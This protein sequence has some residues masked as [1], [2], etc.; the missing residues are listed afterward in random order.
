MNRRHFLSAS[1]LAA[2]GTLFTG[3][4]FA[5][6]IG[7][8]GR[9]GFLAKPHHAAK[10]K[11][12]IYLYMSGGPSQFESFD[13]KPMLEKMD[14]KPMPASV[15]A[16]QQLAQI[17]G[18]KLNCFGPRFKFAKHGQSGVEISDKFP[19]L[20]KVADE[21]AVV[22]SLFT[23]QINHDPANTLL[24]TGSIL[25]DRPSM[26]SWIDYALGADC[27]DL[28]GFVVMESVKGGQGQP[29]AGR[30]WASGALPGVHQ[31]VKLNSRGPLVHFSGNP[32]GV[33]KEQQLAVAA[34]SGVLNRHAAAE[35]ADIEATT[36]SQQLEMALRMQ[37]SIPKLVD[38]SK[39]PQSTLDLY[40]CKP[41]DGSFASNC[42]M[43]RR[44]VEKGCRFIQLYHRDWDHHG[45]I[46]GQFPVLAGVVD[47]GIYALITDLKQRG[48][49]DDTL[50]V[51]SGEFGRTPMSQG[52]NGRDHHM[53]CFSAFMA[54]GGIKGGTTHG[55]SDEFG[56]APAEH[57]HHIR[58]WH[59]TILHQL[60]LDSEQLSI[61]LDGLD[62]KLTGV[63]KAKVIKQILS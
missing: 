31:G 57:P 14:G 61:K 44:L 45:N 5:A 62:W 9:P 19:E 3:S 38:F 24:N 27:D 29:L 51:W 53:K 18:Q 34:A 15:T 55:S 36:R 23:D 30:Y 21:L 4:A 47:R 33:N 50:I 26:G 46:S 12:V 40:G 25:P 52:G 1:A 54:G 60:G 2:C 6:D 37:E 7:R 16:G 10:A 11:R 59:A 32:A 63:E 17:Q 22:R 43:A 42:L 41:G 13:Y 58:D 39:E 20:A 56:F 48:L 28:P 35:W 49:L 8:R